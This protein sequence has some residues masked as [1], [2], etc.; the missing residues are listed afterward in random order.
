[1][2]EFGDVDGE[3]QTARWGLLPTPFGD[4]VEQVAHA[5]HRRLDHGLRDDASGAGSGALPTPGAG[6]VPD[7]ETLDVI[8]VEILEGRDLG[9]SGGEVVRERQQVVDQGFDGFRTQHRC[10]DG[11]VTQQCCANRVG[12]RNLGEALSVT[13]GPPPAPWWCVDDAGLKQHLSQ[14]RNPVAVG[15]TRRCRNRLCCSQCSVEFVDGIGAHAADESA[16]PG[17]QHRQTFT[18]D[19]LDPLR[20]PA[21]G[22]PGGPDC[23]EPVRVAVL[24]GSAETGEVLDGRKFEVQPQLAASDEVTQQR[25]RPGAAQFDEPF[26]CRSGHPVP[27]VRMRG[28]EGGRDEGASAHRPTAETQAGNVL[29]VIGQHRIRVGQ[30]IDHCE[31]GG[32]HRR[33]PARL[34]R[35]APYSAASCATDRCTYP[36]VVSGDTCPINSRNAIRSIPAE[37]SSVP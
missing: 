25:P 12:H 27:Q 37:A 33:V 6:A 34:A 18:Q 17:E 1:M 28:E 14:P 21:Q 2:I 24:D 36:A 5:Q 22:Q 26:G 19:R 16:V 23:G 13:A 15:A 4:V 9:M 7:E 35:A 20:C 3:N 29:E 8:A 31:R 32:G 10:P 30:R 11:D